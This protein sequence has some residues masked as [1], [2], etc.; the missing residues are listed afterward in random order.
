M[1]S[2]I[3]IIMNIL[4]RLALL[5]LMTALPFKMTA[6]EPSAQQDKASMVS[7]KYFGPYA[8]PVPDLLEGQI[9]SGFEAELACDVVSGRIG[10]SGN[11]DWT[12]APTFRLSIPL[13]TDRATFSLWGEFH[14]FYSDT[15]ATRLARSIAPDALPLK[16][17]DSGN[18]YFSLEIQ[19]LKEKEFIPS[20]ALRASTLTATGDNSEVARHY[21]APGYFF[22]ISAGKSFRAG[23]SGSIRVSATSGF[24]CWQIGRGTQND[25]LLL[26]AKLSYSCP[27]ADIQL[28]YGQY[29]G[30]EKDWAASLGIDSGDFPQSLKARVSLHL[31]SFSPFIYMQYGLQ[32]WP[33]TQIR[34]GLTWSFDL[35]GHFSARQAE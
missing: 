17:N 26:G 35:F 12:I 20:I 10:G 28:E 5:C 32:D 6:Q 14:E 31:G 1:E 8:F 29:K 7:T 3:R 34:A 21:D 25:A 13:W 33:F 2:H 19:A 22:D 24:V 9:H 18:L 4:P 30:R 11:R 27:K 16:G 15:P 23:K